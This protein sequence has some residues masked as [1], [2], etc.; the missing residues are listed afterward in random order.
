MRAPRARAADR[1]E[2]ACAREWST[3]GHDRAALRDHRLPIQR[4]W[5]AV[6][7]SIGPVDQWLDQG[8]V[9]R[10]ATGADQQSGG[11][12]AKRHATRNRSDANPRHGYLRLYFFL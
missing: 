1:A 6:P 7:L 12:R 5:F 10:P 8:L 2:S 4:Q 11:L 3:D 9:E